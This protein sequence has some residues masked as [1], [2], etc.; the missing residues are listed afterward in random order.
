MAVFKAS[1]KLVLMGGLGN[2]LFQ[3]AFGYYVL[4]TTGKSVVLVD[5]NSSI[6][7]SSSGE[8]EV[9]LYR[10]D[11]MVEEFK[12]GFYADLVQRG[13]GLLLRLSLKTHVK[14]LVTPVVASI[15]CILSFITTASYHKITTV[16]APDDLGFAKWSPSRFNQIAIG[17]FQSYRYLNEPEVL[18]RM[19][20]LVPRSTEGEVEFY[21]QL[22][23]AEIP[24][25]VHIRQGDYRD[26]PKIG[27]LPSDYY[28]AAIN[29]QMKSG[30][31]NKIWVFSD[32]IL[33][34]QSY[35]PGQFH[36]KVRLIQSVGSNSVSLLEVMRMCKGFVI[37]NS[38]LS[39]W[40]ASMSFSV[41]PLVSYPD[42]WFQSIPTPRD[43]M[44]PDW[45]AVP[46]K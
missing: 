29:Q 1:V 14:V 20:S 30:L 37:A 40:A 26:E 39:W 42:P 41:K 19:K 10:T 16:F 24:L 18:A 45:R 25:L 44:D 4:S 31:Y 22:L 21:Q 8:P 32:E 11:F 34:Y 13:F 27:I 7:R 12:S 38:T 43:L 9:M 23:I 33:E 5:S 28:H 35:I 36:E 46:R 17:Y 15:R 6:R 2:Q 3:L